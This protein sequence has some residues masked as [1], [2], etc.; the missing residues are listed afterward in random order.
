MDELE[1]SEL[2]NAQDQMNVFMDELDDAVASTNPDDI[3]RHI[4]EALSAG[5]N[6]VDHLDEAMD[7]SEDPDVV[8]IVEEA[9][10]HMSLSL[11]Q[12]DQALEA[13]DDEM[14][15]YLSAMRRHAEQAAKYISEAMAGVVR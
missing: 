12:G 2:L 5:S 10:R 7:Q 8:A 11:D 13:P 9:A 3:R 14:D 4:S 1:H 15:G 6:V